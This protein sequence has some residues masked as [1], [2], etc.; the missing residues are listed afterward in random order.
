MPEEHPATF[1]ESEFALVADHASIGLIRFDASLHVRTANLAAHHA[2]ERRPGTLV[3]QTLMGTFVDHRL[4]ELVRAAAAGESGGRELDSADHSS[5]MVRARPASAGGAWVTLENVTELQRLR[6][7]RSEFMDNLSHEL[8]TPLANIR[9]LTEMLMDDLEKEEV[10]IRVRDRVATIDVE[11]G[12]LV[13]MVNELLDLSRIEQASTQ[14]RHD[15][16]LLGPLIA[17]S[18]HRLRTFAERQGVV[19]IELVPDDLPPVRGDEERLDQL[20]MNLLHNAIKFSPDGGTVTI[21]SDEQPDGVVVS[22]T[23]HGVG[24]PRKDQD[25]VFERFYKVDR[26]RQRGLGG[27]G[28]GLAIAKHIA[29]A[30]GGR[31][32]LESIEGKGST[33]SF[34]V[35]FA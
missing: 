26:A 11:T 3:G 13:Q 19:L 27:T 5:V 9:L 12:H 14:I 6:R 4:E 32:W 34:A 1:S 25:R 8:R 23:D 22:V 35:P 2:L 30:H 24:I 18:L 16:V 15:E 33:F 28:L 7:M 20:L 17:A 29:E 21:T 10:S 31:I